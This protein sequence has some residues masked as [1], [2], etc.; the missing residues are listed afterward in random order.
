MRRTIIIILVASSIL[1]GLVLYMDRQKPI[2]VLERKGYGEGNKTEELKV[3]IDGKE[4]ENPLQVELEEE[5]YTEEELQQAFQEVMERLDSIVLGKNESFDRVET[6]LQ[7]VSEV[8]GYPILIRWQMDSYYV[9]GADGHIQTEHTT[10]KGSLVEICGILSYRDREAMYRRTVCVYPV[11]KK[12]QEAEAERIKALFEKQEGENREE[13]NVALPS[14][15]DGRELTWETPGDKRGYILLCLGLLLAILLPAWK[16]EKEREKRKK[17]EEEL[18]VDYPKMLGNFTLLLETGMTVKNVWERIVK[19]Y[20]ENQEDMGK[21]E[22]YQEMS[23]TYREM[24]SGIAEADAYERFA[25]RCGLAEYRKFAALLSQNLKKG[26]K[27]TGQLLYMEALQATENRKNRAK[28]KAEEAGTKLLIPMFGM[29]CI[30]IVIIIVPAFL[31][32]KM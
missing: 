25:K 4:M 15:I 27:G 3:Y 31:S 23:E 28:R 2:D 8:E 24:K 32:M 16:K 6:D 30:V 17:R 14:E 13:K 7:L 19:Q 21:R 20:E 18:L 9:I 26:A 5:H 1:T 22:V 29:L 12:G 11:T 10:E